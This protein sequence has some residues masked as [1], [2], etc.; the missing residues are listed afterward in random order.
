MEKQPNI[1]IE[2]DEENN[3]CIINLNP[4]IYPME[5]IYTA[6]YVFIDKAY[7]IL[8]GDTKKEIKV[9][10]KPKEDYDVEK[11]GMEFH[12]ELLS[13]VLYHEKN[14]QNK[15]IRD[16]IIQRALLANDPDID[17]GLNVN[18]NRSDPDF[19][20]IEKE[21]KDIESKADDDIEDIAIP[22]EDKYGE[23]EEDEGDNK[24]EDK[25]KINDESEEEKSKEGR[26]EEGRNEEEKEDK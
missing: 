4:S 1:P 8:D 26:S 15:T 22:W 23:A 14:K 21:I 2:I 20:E 3:A 24:E 18:A 17:L 13:Y 10:L 6:S 19:A 7:V 16:T 9:I 5:V 11:L 12:N 25:E